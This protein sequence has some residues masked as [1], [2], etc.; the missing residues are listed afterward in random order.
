MVKNTWNHTF[1]A[2]YSP[3]LFP[4]KSFLVQ[5]QTWIT[6]W[7]KYF[8]LNQPKVIFN[9]NKQRSKSK[10]VISQLQSFSIKIKGLAH[11]NMKIMSLITHPHVVPNL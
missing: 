10:D 2:L 6:S 9:M 8:K 4:R 5:F 7:N 11:P 1:L 3:H